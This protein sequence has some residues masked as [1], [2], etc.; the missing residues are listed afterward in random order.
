VAT[1]VGDASLVA[2]LNLGREDSL[3]ERRPLSVETGIQ[4]G[5]GRGDGV[6]GGRERGFGIGVLGNRVH[7]D[8]SARVGRRKT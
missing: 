7:W 5:G 8:P 2:N 1:F 4:G 6:V 3:A